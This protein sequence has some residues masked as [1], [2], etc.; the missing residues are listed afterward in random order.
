MIAVLAASLAL[1]GCNTSYNYFI[2]DEPEDKVEEPGGFNLFKSVMAHSGVAPRPKQRLAYK[3]R[4][5]LAMPSSTELPAP[6]QRT[7]RSQAEQA[8]NFPVDHADAERERTRELRRVLSGGDTAALANPA[9][10]ARSTRALA[11]LPAEALAKP[12]RRDNSGIFRDENPVRSPEEMK[13]RIRIRR[14]DAAVLT[15]DGAAAPRRYL[16]QPPAEYR[17]P[18]ATAA[19]PEEGDIE[20][21]EWFN[22]RR[23]RNAPSMGK[24][25]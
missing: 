21:S 15:E 17:T 22:K 4:A 8:V 10:S 11:R 12:P 24:D 2:D 5:P 14:P 13:Q 6:R 18:A 7:E 1:A 19:L 16:I 9:G 20:N 23:Y 25:R 3:P